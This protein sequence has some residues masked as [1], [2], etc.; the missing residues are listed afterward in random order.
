MRL[1]RSAQDLDR[2]HDKTDTV[3]MN[4]LVSLFV[5]VA[6]CAAGPPRRPFRSSTEY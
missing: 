3:T 4:E 5:F 6:F 1:L 2:R